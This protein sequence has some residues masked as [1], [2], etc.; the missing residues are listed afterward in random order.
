M[1]PTQPMEQCDPRADPPP[2]HACSS[3]ERRVTAPLLD[4]YLVTSRV[5]SGECQDWPA[6][7]SKLCFVPG[8]GTRELELVS[9]W[10]A[11]EGLSVGEL[12]LERFV[13]FARVAPLGWLSVVGVAALDARA[14]GLSA[15]DRGRAGAGRGGRRLSAYLR[16]IA[17]TCWWSVGL[18]RRRS[19]PFRRDARFSLGAARSGRA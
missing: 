10:L 9:R 14:A 1:P 3:H 5:L 2:G 12:T 18:C 16:S 11:G 6:M 19:S 17:D 4:R 15:G 7:S 13:E 8:W